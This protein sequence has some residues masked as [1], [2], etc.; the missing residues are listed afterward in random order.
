MAKSSSVILHR[1]WRELYKPVLDKLFRESASK[2]VSLTP[3]AALEEMERVLESVFLCVEEENNS[4]RKKASTIRPRLY[5]RFERMALRRKAHHY[6][7]DQ[8]YNTYFSHKHEAVHP[9]L[10]IVG[11][12]RGRSALQLG[13]GA[14]SQP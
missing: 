14:M 12:D 3:D 10:R 9:K 13:T 8:F 7:V 11:S 6:A 5:F 2:D 4:K 1:I